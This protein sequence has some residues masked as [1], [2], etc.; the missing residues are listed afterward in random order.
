MHKP[1][2]IHMG[3]I[4]LDHHVSG[5]IQIN[6]GRGAGVRLGQPDHGRD[7]INNA[8]EEDGEGAIC[9][10]EGGAATIVVG[11]ESRFGVERREGLDEGNEMVANQPLDV[12]GVG[13]S[14]GAAL[15][16]GLV[17]ELRGVLR[18]LGGTRRKSWRRRHRILRGGIG[19]TRLGRE[20]DERACCFGFFSFDTKH[21][22]IGCERGRDTFMDLVYFDI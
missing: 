18:R 5:G 2:P 14:R 22:L 19:A 3:M 8:G 17:E 9:L 7:I 11:E 6:Q 4:R 12:F 16:E 20:G 10:E 1:R 13:E 15:R 21:R